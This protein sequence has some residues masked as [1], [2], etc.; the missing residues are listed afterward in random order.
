M[1]IYPRDQD[2][3]RFGRL[4]KSNADPVT[5]ITWWLTNIRL[6]PCFMSQAGA[7]IEIDSSFS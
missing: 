3:I 6:S 2:G 4:D 1:H 7:L 5:L